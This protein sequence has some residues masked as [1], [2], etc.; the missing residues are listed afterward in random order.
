M[1]KTFKQDKI[2]IVKHITK[3]LNEFAWLYAMY[4]L[5]NL[6]IILTVM[7]TLNNL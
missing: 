6:E 4:T 7:T 3:K 2:Y 1:I 5:F